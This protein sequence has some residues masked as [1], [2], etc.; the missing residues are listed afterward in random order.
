[1]RE[2]LC[3]TRSAHAEHEWWNDQFGGQW[4]GYQAKCP[5]VKPSIPLAELEALVEAWTKH[6]SDYLMDFE[7]DA[8]SY[9][10]V[11]GIGMA[12]ES[13]GQLIDKHR[14]S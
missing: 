7:P 14:L 1:M 5:G 6:G 11:E 8:E 4:G 2:V 3:D 9:A 13:L 12:V 10:W